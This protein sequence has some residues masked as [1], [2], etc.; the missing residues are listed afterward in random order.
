MTRLKLNMFIKMFAAIAAVSAV[1][2][3]GMLINGLKKSQEVLYQQKSEDMVRIIDQTSQFLDLYAQT[4][5]NLSLSIT[6]NESLI[7]YR[8]E[9]I[10]RLLE[11]YAQTNL[12]IASVMYYVSADHAHIT[13]SKPSL[14][15]VIDHPMLSALSQQAQEFNQFFWSEP[16]YSPIMTDR[17]LAFVMPIRDEASRQSGALIIE[18]NLPKLT[19]QLYKYLSREGQSFLVTSPS[20]QIIAFDSESSLIPYE[21]GRLP[22]KVTDEFLERVNR[23]N[24]GVSELASTS[25]LMTVKSNDNYMGWYV[26]SLTDDQVYRKSINALVGTYV[27]I[28]LIW[29]SLLLVA[30]F[31]ISRHFTLPIRKLMLQMK[32]V[33]NEKFHDQLQPLNRTDEIGELSHRF[34]EMLGRIRELMNEQ[35][36]N[37][38]KKKQMEIK[39]LLSQI[40]PHFLYNTLACIGSLAKQGKLNEVQ[41]TIRSLILLLKY[42][43]DKKQEMVSLYEEI[44]SLQAYIQIQTI[45]V[46]NEFKVIFDIDPDTNVYLVP[47]LMLQPIV[48]NSIFHGISDQGDGQILIR[49]AVSPQGVIITVEDNGQGIDDMERVNKLL[50]HRSAKSRQ[51]SQSLNSMEL[52]NVQE[53]IQL[54]FGDDYG[55][56]ITPL[57]KGGTQVRILI[58]VYQQSTI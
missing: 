39:M 36:M 47:K 4:L 9:Q 1:L 58:P 8:P 29:F 44:N 56:T 14:I 11:D 3:A 15:S 30:C 41:E 5:I 12:Q 38:E 6:R 27:R 7:S 16:Y 23:L 35:Q 2:Y 21:R 33:S 24:N 55:M 53:R 25:K 17:T 26:I 28:G 51:Q 50:D 45:R 22:I 37:E 57:E 42:S 46:G 20:G 19:E 10:A 18:V 13:G 31:L 32:W 48:E 43:I 34:L 49:S 54:H 40:R 52:S